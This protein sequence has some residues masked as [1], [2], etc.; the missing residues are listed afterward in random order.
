MLR[1][2]IL[3]LMCISNKIYVFMFIDYIKWGNTDMKRVG[4][5]YILQ[6]GR[7]YLYANQL[8]VV[9]EPGKEHILPLIVL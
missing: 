5:E 3:F 1:L 9:S 6:N 8:E 4:Y 7:K 2:C